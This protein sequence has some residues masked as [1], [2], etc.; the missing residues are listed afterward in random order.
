MSMFVLATALL[1]QEQSEGVF[2]R[3]VSPTNTQFVGIGANGVLVWSNS[4]V[5]VTCT[6]QRATTLEGTSKL[7]GLC[8]EC[9]NRRSFLP[10]GF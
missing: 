6:V 1:A 9:R 8:A 7:D 5:G 10:S 4:T 2:F 3:I